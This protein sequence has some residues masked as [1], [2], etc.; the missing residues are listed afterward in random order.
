MS[1]FFLRLGLVTSLLVAVLLVGC[2]GSSGSAESLPT[3]PFEEQ[4][5]GVDFAKDELIRL[6]VNFDNFDSKVAELVAS[7]TASGHF[8][9]VG[10][11]VTEDRLAWA[12]FE[13]GTMMVIPFNRKPSSVPPALVDEIGRAAV[14]FP[15]KTN[16]A[17][18]NTF[19]ADSYSSGI[20]SIRPLLESAGYSQVLGAIGTPREGTL[21]DFLNLQDAGIL[22]VDGHGVTA[23][24]PDG[25]PDNWLYLG[26]KT[27]YTKN[28]KNLY[29][30][31]FKKRRLIVG[32]ESANDKT[33]VM[34]SDEF[35]K[36]NVKVAPKA[37]IFLNTCWNGT[38]DRMANAFFANG[39]GTVV[40]WNKAVE[41]SDAYNTSLYLFDRLLGLQTLVPDAHGPTEPGWPTLIEEVLNDMK[42]TVRPG[43]TYNF[44]VD[45]QGTQLKVYSST[46]TARQI[47]PSI[48]VV[49]F[50]QGANLI[51][52]RGE[53]G[54]DAGTVVG[55]PGAVPLT[56]R[57]W[58]STQIEVS[59][60][61]GITQVR[62]Q[63]GSLISNLGNV[64]NG[65]FTY[66]EEVIPAGTQQALVA[67]ID[68]PKSALARGTLGVTLIVNGVDKWKYVVGFPVASTAIPLAN[69][70]FSQ[71]LAPSSNIVTSL[72]GGTYNFPSMGYP[73]VYDNG[74]RLTVVMFQA[75]FGPISGLT[76]ADAQTAVR[77][78]TAGRTVRFT[79]SLFDP[80]NTMSTFNAP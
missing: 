3:Q 11:D 55:L 60:K 62:V 23:S 32:L 19:L 4:Q 31:D 48:R 30:D 59:S 40:S 43:Q 12:I 77:N 36:S 1:N 79:K 38:R 66:G 41:D 24:P 7:L 17:L 20:G 27:S 78:G 2:G 74:D 13:D 57:S 49:S 18:L 29:A 28:L 8:K 58:T 35:V 45:R 68:I 67:F 72:D 52:I 5:A 14:G 51:G 76:L 64:P 70:N 71:Y 54:P 10:I 69:T 75:G 39:A 16:S 25:S 46:D 44:D 47:L 42:T 9:E 50:D 65:N 80:V 33:M 26:A 53:F 21:N 15:G 56:V 73:L 37:F 63:K 6:G 61:P 22:Y 34:M